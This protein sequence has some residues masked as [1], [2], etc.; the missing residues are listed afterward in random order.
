M[1]SS[2][3]PLAHPAMTFFTR[4]ATAASQALL[5]SL[6]AR[7]IR[8]ATGLLL[9]PTIAAAQV[10][11]NDIIPSNF[12]TVGNAN[13]TITWR[14]CSQVDQTAAN[15]LSFFT[16]LNTTTTLVTTQGGAFGICPTYSYKKSYS[17]PASLI[18]GRNNIDASFCVG[19]SCTSI[20]V[21]VTYTPGTPGLSITPDGGTALPILVGN[22]GSFVFRVTN[23][24]NVTA[25]PVVNFPCPAFLQNC[26]VTSAGG[27]LNPTGFVDVTASYQGASAGSAQIT[28]GGNLLEYPSTTDNGTASVAV[29]NPPSYSVSV[30]VDDANPI[31]LSA[32]ATSITQH[33]TISN[34]SQNTTTPSTFTLAMTG[35]LPGLSCPPLDPMPL[36]PGTL[37]SNSIFVTCNIAPSSVATSGTVRLTASTLS[38]ATFSNFVERTVNTTPLVPTY[39][40][41]VVPLVPSTT[42]LAR[43]TA[44]SQI[45]IVTNT[46]QN[47]TANS[48][49]LS[50]VC[51][52]ALTCSFSMSPV[53]I[54]PNNPLQVPVPYGIQLTG[55]GGTLQLNASVGTNGSG[56]GS[57]TVNTTPYFEAAVIPENASQTLAVGATSGSTRFTVKNNSSNTMLLGTTRTF[58]L[59]P[60]CGSPSI[61]TCT[62]TPV[63]VA[64]H[65]QDSTAT[66]GVTVNYNVSNTGTGGPLLLSASS[67]GMTTVSATTNVVTT[68]I[69]PAL[70]ITPDGG[71][72]T[73]LLVGGSGSFVFKVR[74]TGNVPATPVV[75]SDCSAAL[76]SC[77]LTAAGGVLSPGDSVSLTASYQAASAGAARVALTGHFVE[78]PTVIDSGT[79]NLTVTRAPAYSVSVTVS[80]YDPSNVAAGTTSNTQTYTITNTS[81]FTSATTQFMLAMS[82]TGLVTSCPALSILP[83]NLAPG[84]SYTISVACPIGPPSGPTT[85]TVR[86]TATAISP[87]FSGFG[88]RTVNLPASWGPAVDVSMN[89]PDFQS[90]TLCEAACFAATTSF[91]TVPYFSLDQPRK[92]TLLY[93]SDQAVP[94]P[95]I[96]ADVNG[97]STVAVTQYT[98]Q[99]TLN[100][101]AVTFLNG[102]TLLTFTG[103]QPNAPVRLGGQ[104]DARSFATNVYPLVVTV[105]A[106]YANG[107]TSA[108]AVVNSTFMIVNEANSEIAKGW[109]VAGRQRL[110]ATASPGYLVTNG[111][112][113]AT[114]FSALGVQAADFTTLTYDPTSTTY[115]RTYADGSR[116]IFNA[117]RQHTASVSADRR[118]VSYGYLADGRLQY[119]GDPFR[120]KP[121]GGLTSITL[122]Y[123][124]NGLQ[125]IQEPGA[126]GTLGA[127][128]A[129]TFV[130]NT[131]RCLTTATDPDA[132]ASTF[133]CDT[134]ARLATLSN[135]KT[136]VT[137]LVYG[138]SWKLS[139]VKLP[140]I[141]VDAGNGSTTNKIPI[142]TYTPWQTQGVPTSSTTSNKPWIAPLVSSVVGS[143][144]DPVGG[145]T[146]FK[147]NRFG[148]AID[149]TDPVGG[150]TLITTGVGFLPTRVQYPNGAVDTL[151]YDFVGRVTASHPAG[152]Y[153]AIYS[154]APGG[155]LDITSGRGARFEQRIYDLNNQLARINFGG[156]PAQS[157]DFTYDPATK[158]VA[159]IRDNSGHTTTYAYDATFGNEQQVILPGTR[160]TSKT[161]DAIGR[162]STFLDPTANQQTSL[163]DVMNRLT[164]SSR[165]G[166]TITTSYD[167]LFQTD[168]TDANGNHYHTDYNAL[169]LPIKNCDALLKC[170][171]M[172][173]DVN[174]AVS[175]TTNRRNLNLTVSRDAAGRV[176][177]QTGSGVVTNNYSYA[178][179]GR[180]MVAWNTIER[181]SIFVDPGSQSLPATDSVVSW[182]DAA[183]RFRVFHRASRAVADTALTTVSSNTGVV[184]SDR[185]AIY[186]FGGFLS[187]MSIGSAMTSFVPDADGTG[188]TTTLPGGGTRTSYALATHVTADVVFSA[189]SLVN[190]FRRQYHYDGGNRIDQ[191][192]TGNKTEFSYDGLGRLFNSFLVTGCSWGGPWPADTISGPSPTCTTP[193]SS[194]HFSY[195]AMGNRTD[196]GGVP[197]TGNRY[198]TFKGA[199][200]SYDFD[201][202]V[203]QKD[204]G[205]APSN[206]KWYWNARN[207]L[208]SAIKGGTLGM[209]YDYNA[210]GKPVRIRN[211]SGTQV[212][213][214]L[215]WDGD[216]LLGEF[217]ANGQRQV[218][219]V[220]LPG[221]IDRP[222]AHTLGA[223]TPTTVRY[224]EIDELGNVVG[225]SESGV[226]SQNNSYDSWGVATSGGNSDQ[227][228]LWKGLFWAGDTTALYNVRN[229]WYDPEGGRFVNEDPAGFDGG[230]NLY[231]FAGNDPINESDPSGLGGLPGLPGTGL[232]CDLFSCSGN[233]SR[234]HPKG[235]KL[236]PLPVCTSGHEVQLTLG[237]AALVHVVTGALGG[238]V[239]LG[240]TLPTGRVILQWSGAVN[241]GLG[242]GA[243]AGVTGAVA[244]QPTIQSGWPPTTGFAT[245]GQS[246]WGYGPEAWGGAVMRDNETGDWTGL[247]GLYGV[248]G[249][250]QASVGEQATTRIATPAFFNEARR[251]MGLCR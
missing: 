136:S 167:Q 87:V 56:Q 232:L 8:L 53:T 244:W 201:G 27:A 217:S 143:V 173:Y 41:T 235:R 162:D 125:K 151:S 51:G 245:V 93:N 144:A 15:G 47:T 204:N 147:P 208:D 48:I 196:Q 207:Q 233:H 58:S 170:S 30:T 178:A 83:I 155:L 210:F 22:S 145:T 131:S 133:T 81:Q 117:I 49:S 108:P 118:T 91:S 126:D 69:A 163:Y 4:L 179:D 103:S 129:T 215:V 60:T 43:A 146:T 14:A 165:A 138:A 183:K 61:P 39:S 127:G 228:L 172:R 113:S 12:S 154:Y 92:V 184:F 141:P 150:R 42:E 239:D 50:R 148:Q 238:G 66:W 203:T 202:N 33:Y 213:K 90:P 54:N 231:A 216:A 220:Y 55:T 160:I 192:M 158:R 31:N 79:A 121:Q 188:G 10:L 75:S 45:F 35:T 59:P 237:V 72:A 85:G 114:R 152:Q 112:R 153:E 16:K 2:A 28:V 76:Q 94:R 110:Y 105:Q 234:P 70:S 246:N 9:L 102:Q 168:L 13:I 107:F 104:F 98:M 197:T 218:D 211:G 96:Y 247:M 1:R 221:T 128:R 166:N 124:A 224:H 200:Y 7:A 139:Q 243:F 164:S 111:D 38:P 198:I 57:M 159:S 64:L 23:S 195:D 67:A 175:S 52:G 74:N 135:R 119:I 249:G 186:G 68:P 122:T 242:A 6:R 101:T 21:Q 223:T 222:F 40:V 194:D 88:Q 190:A 161:F 248:G 134:N 84:A 130:V 229:R 25:T 206:R 181:D 205:S 156:F 20:S 227:H 193:V 37:N 3:R 157:L 212:A 36:N 214:Y 82:R 71:T 185:V 169:G 65:D 142:V 209:S 120:T 177:S 78:Y 240:V 116:T 189:P 225:T 32:G 73:S 140:T 26:S 97:S 241:G 226:V 115:T 171:T 123:D 46:S 17:A 62:S 149:V 219:Y 180:S 106:K 99:A 34:T 95:F 191:I 5:Q 77:S 11:I 251:L 100:G 24:G 182:I 109:I 132:I 29:S 18:V 176:T 86:L 187:S 199:S 19:G 250:A 230:V 80:G 174:G 44:G 63:S 137:T 236:P 89:N